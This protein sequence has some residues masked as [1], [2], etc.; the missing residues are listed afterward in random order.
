[1]KTRLDPPVRKSWTPPLWLLTAAML[2]IVGG[3]SAWSAHEDFTQ[4]VN[5]EYR[6]LE[7]RARQREARISGALRSVDLMLRSIIDEQHDHPTMSVAENNMLLKKHLRQLPELRNLVIVDAVGRIRAEANETS[8]GKDASEREYFKQHRTEPKNDRYFV[9]RP[10]K[11][12][13]GVT[14]TTLSRVIRDQSGRFAGVAVASID[15]DFFSRTLKF[16]IATPG[17]QAA[18]INFDGDILSSTPDNSI[19]GQNLKGGIAYTEHMA[20]AQATTRHRNVVKLSGVERMSV[21]HNLPDAP[22]AVIVLRD[23]ASV[24]ADWRR[25]LYGHVAGF[26][27][28]AATMLFFSWLATR[29]QRSLLRANRKIAERELELRAIIDTEPE[30][31]KQLAAD[32]SLLQMN[33]AGLDMIEADSLDQVVGQQVKGLVLPEYREAFVALIDKVFAGESGKL[34]FEIQGLKGGHRWL[35]THATPLRNAERQVTA[36]LGITRDITERKRNEAELER[37]RY[38]LEEQVLARTFELA[39]ARDDAE[40]ASR[41]KSTFLANMSHELRTPMNGIMGMTDLALRRA[42]DPKQI[43]QL[44]NSKDSAQRLLGVINNV[45]EISNIEAGRLS[46]E[47]KNFSLRQLIDEALQLQDAAAREKGMTLSPSIDPELPAELCGDAIRLK[48][49]LGTFLS[50]AVKF[51]ERG[52]ISVYAHAAEQDRHS[53]L[54]RIEVSD[55]GIGVSPEQQTRLFSTFTQA[56]GSSTRKHG[57]TGLGLA[58]A[59]RIAQLMGGDVGVVSE[60]GSGS[61][62]WLAVRLRRVSLAS[63]EKRS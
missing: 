41:A 46:L 5:L 16:N 57:G 17:T 14:A 1:M 58:I 37:H 2:L 8:I 36:L 18:L 9:A 28:L 26:A 38:H 43:E 15:A 56:D 55:Q 12:F 29:R 6:M 24:T 21:F 48:Q 35:E 30:C 44:K 61:T 60:Q 62:F 47:E 4:L 39:A 13:S 54:L 3:W 50:N 22:L 7:I 53:V 23:M 52:A 32:G 20:S 11:A 33:R 59:R 40:A 34:E 42:T 49:I 10:F 45:L 27:L 63:Q 19:A 25:S 31:V 51:S